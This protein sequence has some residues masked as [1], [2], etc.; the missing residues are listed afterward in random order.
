M[1]QPFSSFVYRNSTCHILS[2]SKPVFLQ[3]PGRKLQVKILIH[4]LHTPESSASLLAHLLP[5]GRII[6]PCAVL[7]VT[8]FL[9]IEHI[10]R[11]SLPGS[12]FNTRKLLLLCR[13]TLFGCNL[14]SLTVVL[15]PM[16]WTAEHFP[17]SSSLDM[18]EDPRYTISLTSKAQ[19]EAHCHGAILSLGVNQ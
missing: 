10:Q 4:A 3:M 18:L 11:W 9:V 2:F 5:Q 19:A 16:K 7:E 8:F 17:F 6:S 1:L 13:L 15:P 12:I 14:I